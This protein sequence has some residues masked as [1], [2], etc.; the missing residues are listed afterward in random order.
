MSYK[1]AILLA[2]GDNSVLVKSFIITADE[3]AAQWYSLLSPGVIHRWDDLKQWMLSNFQGFQRLELIESDLFSCKQ[4]DKEPLQNYFKRFVH[5]RDQAPNVLDAVAINAAIVGLRADQFRSHLMRERAKTIQCLYE[6]F[7]RY[8]RSDNDFRMCM[9]EQSHQKESAEANQS[10]ER[11]WPNPRNNSHANPRNVF[12]LDG[13]NAQENPNT[14]GDSQ[15]QTPSLPSPPHSN[16][17]G[18][19]RGGRGGDRGRG[20]GRGRGHQEKRKWYCIFHKENDDHSSNYFPDKKRFEAILE[21]EKKEKER[22]SAINHSAPAWQNH[23]FRRNSFANP[24]QPPQ[25]QPPIPTYTQPP[26]WQSQ[27]FQA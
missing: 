6:E 21:E 14:Q 13:E 12:G 1:A 7:E 26:P 11:E 9:E 16:K 22:T 24:F 3:A 2:G 4:K 8:C 10:N 27:A 18:S 19:C 17:G 25:F 15:N 5:L 20:R 23:D